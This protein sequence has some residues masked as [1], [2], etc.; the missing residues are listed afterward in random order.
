MEDSG[1]KCLAKNEV[2]IEDGSSKT[3]NNL[4]MTPPDGGYGW[5]IVFASFFAN[6]IVDGII[7]SIGKTLVEVWEQDFGTTAMQASL[8]Q[9][10]LAGSEVVRI[11]ILLLVSIYNHINCFQGPLASGLANLFGCRLVVIV[12]SMTTFVGFILSSIVPSLPL[13]YITFGIIGGKYKCLASFDSSKRKGE[14]RILGMKQLSFCCENL[15]K[16]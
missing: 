13:L 9:S 11:L 1:K 6:V 16:L 15:F 10:L 3:N 5:I 12:G 7:Y 2:L 14:K 8:V 4:S